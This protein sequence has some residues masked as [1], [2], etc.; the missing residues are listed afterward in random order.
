LR[1]I[2]RSRIE[3][4]V[5]KVC[6]DLQTKIDTALAVSLGMTSRY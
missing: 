1:V 6:C 4:F 3:S 2:D 5:G